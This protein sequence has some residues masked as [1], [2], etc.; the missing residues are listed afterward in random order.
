MI[1]LMRNDVAHMRPLMRS[2]CHYGSKRIGLVFNLALLQP[3]GL[4]TTAVT[5]QNNTKVLNVTRIHQ[6]SPRC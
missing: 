3:H 6:N 5:R 4:E 2:L 1:L